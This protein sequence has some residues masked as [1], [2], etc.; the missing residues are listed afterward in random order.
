[1]KKLGIDEFLLLARE[2]PVLDVRSPGEYGHAHIPGALSLPLFTDEE[3]KVV[4]T[5]Y[6]QESREQAIKLG[7]DYFGVKMRKMVEEVEAM[8]KNHPSVKKGE[9]PTVLVHCWRGGMRSAGVAWLLDLYGFKV[10]TLVGGYKAYRIWAMKQFSVNYPFKVL[11]GYTG[12]GKTPTL[13]VL[14]KNGEK[15]IDLEELAQHK[16]SAFG[17]FGRVQPSQEMFENLLAWELNK[18]NSAFPTDVPI[19]IEDESQRIGLVNLPNTICASMKLATLYFVHIP[20]AARLL[21]ITAEYGKLKKEELVNSIIRIQKRL[22]GQ[23][24]KLAINYLLEDN[25][26]EC[27]AILLRYY[28]KHYEKSILARS[29]MKLPLVKLAVG[30][31]DAAVICQKLLD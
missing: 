4:G 31:V 16:G 15:T 7:L 29:E 21:H 8:L 13:A 27:F 3:R 17:S 18:V 10:Y 25:I 30:T 20:F 14:K 24:T 9:Q 1:M 28:D 23:N 5:S 6:K 12:S 26:S 19:W 22:G 2:F 11:G